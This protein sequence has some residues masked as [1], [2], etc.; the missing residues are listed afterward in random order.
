MLI[1]DVVRWPVDDVRWQSLTPRTRRRWQVHVR[2]S[3][4]QQNVAG[5]CSVQ[6]RVNHWG[7]LSADDLDIF[8]DLQ[9]FA[10]LQV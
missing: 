3:V 8:I 6:E 2:I 1:G 7:E 4:K 10:I 5:V 9:N